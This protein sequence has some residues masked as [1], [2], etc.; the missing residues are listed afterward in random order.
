[1]FRNLPDG[2]FVIGAEASSLTLVIFEYFVLVY[3]SGLFV[4]ISLQGDT[5]LYYYAMLA[6]SWIK[7]EISSDKTIR[8]HIDI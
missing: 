4:F 1:M 7:P 2:F 3:F 6:V 8:V 5:P